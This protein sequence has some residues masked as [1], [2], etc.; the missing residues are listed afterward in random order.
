MEDNVYCGLIRAGAVMFPNM[1]YIHA[2]LH[3]PDS[4]LQRDGAAGARRAVF[5]GDGMPGCM[6]QHLT[7][8]S[9]WISVTNAP[10]PCAML[11]G[12]KISLCTLASCPAGL[13]APASVLGTCQCSDARAPS[14]SMRHRVSIWSRAMD[15]GVTARARRLQSSSAAKKIILFILVAP[16][17]SSETG[18]IISNVDH[19]EK[20][21]PAAGQTAFL[22]TYIYD[23]LRTERV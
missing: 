18:L 17:A 20:D 1:W 12:V 2:A 15:S 5:T 10:C 21:T 7:Y 11:P 9:V 19:Y 13:R 8:D 16:L 6:G 23:V 14:S 22:I 3:V 4:V